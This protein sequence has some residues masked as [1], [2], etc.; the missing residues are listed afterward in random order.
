MSRGILRLYPARRGWKSQVLDRLTTLSVLAASAELGGPV[1]DDLSRA[2]ALPA[3]AAPTTC[4][5]CSL[6]APHA[7]VPAR[8]RREP[9][10]LLCVAIEGLFTGGTAEARSSPMQC[11]RARLRP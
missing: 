5:S 1:D 2:T 11:F 3:H 7:Q 6:S 4:L 9:L 8:R 10:S